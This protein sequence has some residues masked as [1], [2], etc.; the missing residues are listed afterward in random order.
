MLGDERLTG[1]I[2]S[3]YKGNTGFLD[4]IEKEALSQRIPIIRKDTQALLRF[5]ME[6]YR[7]ERILE[8]GTAVGFSAI[9]MASYTD[10]YCRIFTIENYE[11]RI[12]AARKNIEESGF[13]HRIELIEGDADDVLPALQDRFDMIFIDAAKAQYPFYLKESLRLLKPGGLIAADNCLQ[14][15]DILESRYAVERRNRTIHKRMREFLKD[16]TA[17]E[18]FTSVVLP[19]GDGVT[20]AYRKR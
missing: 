15:G 12:P 8:I 19:I 11:K 20:L 2:N 4:R 10:D 1:Y 14:D 6:S 17:S 3:L 7:P 13:S 5:L 16:I 18:E 9:L